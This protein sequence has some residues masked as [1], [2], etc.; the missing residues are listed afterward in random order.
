MKVSNP[1]VH[2]VVKATIFGVAELNS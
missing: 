2:E 1:I